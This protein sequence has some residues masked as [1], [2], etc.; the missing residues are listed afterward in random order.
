MPQKS[1]SFTTYEER[2]QKKY[3]YKFLYEKKEGWKNNYSKIIIKCKQHGTF[4]S[5]FAA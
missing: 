5:T 4:E 1:V 3:N 2:P